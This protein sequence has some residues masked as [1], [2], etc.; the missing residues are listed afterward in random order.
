MK[1]IPTTLKDVL[2]VEPKVFKDTRGFFMETYHLNRYKKGGIDL[3]FVQDNLSC[4]VKGTVRGLHYQIKHPQAKLVNVIVGEIF[5]V[6]VDIRQGSSTFGQWT[7]IYLSDQNKRQLFIPEGFAHGFCVTSD[8]AL[9]SYKCSDFYNADDEGGIL[10]SDPD[11]AIDWPVDKPIISKK[12]N[13]LPHLSDLSL[14]RLPVS[15]R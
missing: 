12:D 4:S 5:D 1:V 2:I 6:V 11:I 13:H 3:T 9:F 7:G 14:D 10:W 15:Y 8:M